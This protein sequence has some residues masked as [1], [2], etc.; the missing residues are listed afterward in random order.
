MVQS[1]AKPSEIQIIKLTDDMKQGK[2]K[3]SYAFNYGI[4]EKQIEEHVVRED[5]T[6]DVETRTVYE[7]YQYVAD[8]EFDLILKPFIPELLKQ[9][10]KQLEPIIQERLD[11]A[12]AEI[13][14]NITLEG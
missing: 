1:M 7:Y 3:V 2:V 12:S 5:G 4:Q 8:A 14:K 6:T 13:P 9:I 10:Y 11:L